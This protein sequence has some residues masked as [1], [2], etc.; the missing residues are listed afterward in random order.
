MLAIIWKDLI[1]EARTRDIVTSLFVLGLLILTIFQFALHLTPA[2]ARRMAP[3]MLWTAIVLASSLA[4]GRTLIRERE[5]GCLSGLLL[6]PIDRGSVFLAKLVVNVIFL[7]AFELLLLPIFTVMTAAPVAAALPELL[8]VL[9]AGTLGLAAIST[10]FALAA[11]G[12]RARETMLPLI[13]LPLQ[14]PLIIAAVQCTEN[15]L[16]GT[17]VTALGAWGNLMFAYDILFVAVGWLAFEHI[18]VE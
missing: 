6:A 2:E 17:P 9:G 4:I 8:I 16:M 3:G 1:A 12:T 15:V 18:A 11:A 10:L 5:E 13:A 7:T 14:V